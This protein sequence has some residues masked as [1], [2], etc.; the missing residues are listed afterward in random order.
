MGYIY[1]ITNKINN[2]PYVGKTVSSIQD[3]WS[4]HIYDAFT[5]QSDYLI[6]QAMRKYGIENFK[7]EEIE[8]CLN[9][10]LDKREQYWIKTINSH[11]EKGY[12]YNMT[13]G[14]DGA[15]TYSDEDILELWNQGLKSCQIAK[16][17]GASPNTISNRLK[18]LKPGEARKRHSNSNKKAI[19]Q[20]DL[21]GNFIRK[22][23]CAQNA[24]K[25]L[26][27]SSGS[28][29]KCCKHQRTFAKNS[30]WLYEDDTTSITELMINYAQSIKCRDVD[31]IDEQ[32]NILEHFNTAAEAERV[33]GITRGKVS[34]VCNHKRGR[35]TA[36]GYR[37]QWSYPLKRELLNI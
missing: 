21:Y 18:E 17:L 23:D 34:E 27:I 35:K 7:I 30:F 29:N 15:L 36:G 14:G 24:E 22:W 13:Y 5:K 19:L 32:G 8:Q 16:Q 11:F 1:K 37:W 31:L 10:I 33:K 26:N 12:G 6:H 20:Y 2:K 9:A 25:E 28:I 4:N 3:R